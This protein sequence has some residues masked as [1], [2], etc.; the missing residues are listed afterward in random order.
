MRETS[1]R[2]RVT[3]ATAN[4]VLEP[5]ILARHA[6]YITSMLVLC[7]ARH[8]FLSEH[9]GRF[10]EK[11]GID[12]V[13]CVGLDEA[14]KLVSV[15]DP[16]AVICDYDLLATVPLDR[17]ENDPVLSATPIIAVSLTRH[18][19]EAHLVDINGIVGFLYLPTLELDEARQMLNA[20]R[21][22]RP[23]INPPDIRPW[24]EP[25]SAARLR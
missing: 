19:G 21:R 9:L 12:A 1:A 15:H 18:P 16:E 14:S 17:W 24:P 23:A 7:V 25:T 3:I 8:P 2:D 4:F 6:G 10:F 5:L 13:P 20:V 11:L 22:Q